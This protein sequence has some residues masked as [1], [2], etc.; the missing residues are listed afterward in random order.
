MKGW[1]L[2]EWNGKHGKKDLPPMTYDEI[3]EAREYLRKNN[4]PKPMDCPV[5]ECEVFRPACKLGIC[6]IAVG[7]CGNF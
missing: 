3:E 2:S 4:Y 6:R 7:M 5:E 1:K